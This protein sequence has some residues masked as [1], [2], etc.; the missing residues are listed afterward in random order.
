MDL[1]FTVVANETQ[2]SKLV[3]EE[4]D[5]PGVVPTVSAKVSR[6]QLCHEYVG[7]YK[8][9]MNHFHYCPANGERAISK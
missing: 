2:V 5:P 9:P 8:F 6:Q 1:Y 4:I 3:H 7:N